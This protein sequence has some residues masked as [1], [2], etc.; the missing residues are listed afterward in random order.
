MK[1]AEQHGIPVVL[2][3]MAKGM[4][5]ED[6]RCYAGVLFHA[7]SNHVAETHR[8][9]DLVI[10]V[11]YDPVEF[12]YE[13]WIP[14]APLVHIDTKPAD[15]DES[16]HRLECDVVGSLRPAL[17][18][19][20]GLAPQENDW[21]LGALAERRQRMFESLRPQEGSFGP[22]AAVTILREVLPPDGILTCD[23]GAHLHVIGQLWQTPAPGSLL[24]TNGWSSMG[25]GI[26]SAIAAKLCLPDRPVA[27]VVGDGG[28]LMMVG[29]MATAKR[30]GV[31]VV[32]V[33]LTDHSL[34]L[35]RIKQERKSCEIYG[36]PLHGDGYDSAAHFLRRPGASGT[37]R[38]VLPL[39]TW[40]GL[41]GWR[42]RDRRGFRGSERIW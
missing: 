19:L 36:T 4:V 20:A 35:I 1:I 37:R 7:L 21:D 10:G 25:F 14:D 40:R 3:P 2:T 23:V 32:F 27:C 16:C 26:P 24:M 9:A 42:P 39:G 12:N 28:F 11:G 34:E 5:P 29:E 13:D 30:L 31:S 6:H 33:L 8:Q 38:R 18:R 17:E 41:C 22:T 15:L